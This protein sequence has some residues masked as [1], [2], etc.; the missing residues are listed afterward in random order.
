MAVDMKGLVR[1]TRGLTDA[2]DRLFYCPSCSTWRMPTRNPRVAAT[3][4]RKASSL[5]SVTA[6]NAS[7]NIPAHLQPLY[8]A[9]GDLRAKASAHVSLSRLQLAQQGLESESPKIRIAVLGLNVQDTARRI[10]RLLLADA[11]EKEAGWETDLLEADASDKGLLIRYGQP[12]NTNLPATRTSIPT[13]SVPSNVLEK[14]NMEI[15]VSSI[16]SSINSGM[17]NGSRLPANMFLSP[18]I[19]TPAAATGRQT[20]I[21]QPVHSTLVIVK[22]LGEL[23]NLAELLASTSFQSAEDRLS[24]QVAME[25]HGIRLAKQGDPVIVDAQTAEEGIAAIRQSM[26]EAT[27]YEHKWVDSG[28]PALQGWL[29]MISDRAGP[30][31]RSVQTLISSLLTAA[32]SSVEAYIASDQAVTATSSR[33]SLAAR[34]NLESAIDE[35]SR[36]GHSELQS[37]L[38]SAWASRNWQKLAWYK[39]FWRV[40][41]VGLI[42]SDLINNAWLPHTERAVYELSGRLSQAG[43][44]PIDVA[45]VPTPPE[46]VAEA[47]T[48]PS[49]ITH[50]L[51]ILQAQL[52]VHNATS[53]PASEPIITNPTGRPTVS[54]SQPPRPVPLSAS[55]STSRTQTISAAIV[56]LQFTAQQLVFRT[57]SIVGLSGGLSGL[58]Y[59]SL[60]PSIY[61]SGTIVALGTAFALYRMQGSWQRATKQLEEELFD[62]GR[63]AVRNVVGRM[64]QLVALNNVDRE[65]D[66]GMRLAREAMEAVQNAKAEFEKVVA[67]GKVTDMKDQ[68]ERDE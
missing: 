39:L 26:D 37:G 64:R 50:P 10:V 36:N 24:V 2:L 41:D 38:A 23:M 5:S 51:P 29:A 33:L 46:A 61:E 19:G 55:I 65:E 12:A 49:P 34:T 54:L 56:S 30:V 48:A 16:A 27:T 4:S 35:F 67:G 13:L 20:M 21:S 8:A 45:P 68:V 25:Q 47:V 31:P 59:M 43:I 28:I 44:F 14:A 11:L 42:L 32:S 63:N 66:A 1:S 40:D 53:A 6:I 22:G 9:L 7:K 57:L 62:E 52:S 60:T 18:T 3:L 17:H 15:L 58:T